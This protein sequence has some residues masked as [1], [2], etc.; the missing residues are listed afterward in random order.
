M[1]DIK[2]AIENLKEMYPKSGFDNYESEKRKAITLAIRSL[3]AWEE[4]IEEL[5]KLKAEKEMGTS[6]VVVK[7][8]I[9]IVKQGLKE[10]KN[11]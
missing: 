6:K 11:D 8:C 1:T 7:E 4:V 9:D 10:Q 5:E 3:K 2:S